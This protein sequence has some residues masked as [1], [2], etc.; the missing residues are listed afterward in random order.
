MTP[1]ISKTCTIMKLNDVIEKLCLREFNRPSNQQQEI[2][3][4]H[5]SDVMS[6][7]LKS[8]SEGSLWVT[9]QAHRNTVAI[10][11]LR[12]AAAVIFSN[13]I[14][15]QQDIA[16]CATAANITLLGTEAS[17]FEIAGKLYQLLRSDNTHNIF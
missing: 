11:S 15:P 4:C 9:I 17:T 16:D 7:A 12:G 6:D 1:D 5:V 3:E 2:G 13:G 10:A 8:L 14:V